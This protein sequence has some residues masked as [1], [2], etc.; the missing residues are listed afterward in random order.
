M[1]LDDVSTSPVS[2]EPVIR[3][4]RSPTAEEAV[5]VEEEQRAFAE[6]CSGC[7]QLHKE[8]KQS[9]DKMLSKFDLVCE[10]LETLIAEKEKEQSNNCVTTLHEQMSESG[11]EEKYATSPSGSRGSPNPSNGKVISG[12]GGCRKRKPTK[13]SVNRVNSLL[14]NGLNAVDSL[15]NGHGP[16][17]EKSSRQISTPVSASSPFPDFNNFNGFMFDPMTNPQNMM[18]LLTVI[19]QQQQAQQAAHQQQAAQQQKAAELIQKKKEEQIERAASVVKEEPRSS[20]P[21]E[22]NL[23]DQLAAQFNGK[24]PSPSMHTVTTGSPDEDSG[25]SI[26]RCSNCSTTKTT[27]WRRDLTGKLVCNAC[28]LY[29]RLHRT[30][31][32]VHMRKDFIQQRF[33]RK[34]KEEENPSTSQSAMFS[35]LLGLPQL[36]SNGATNAF[37]I[38]EQFNQLNQAQEQLNSS[39]PV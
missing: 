11:S 29:Y 25:S 20:P 13:E 37:S 32:P 30:H 21:N 14:E 2:S 24:A 22:Q 17:A 23:L 33:R 28:G 19:Q 16:S 1:T 3:D 36:P 6:P 26:S 10:R 9:V 7:V 4:E 34:I 38:L 15:L 8:I 18:Q 5:D 27:A 12:N 35:Q 39:A 31:R